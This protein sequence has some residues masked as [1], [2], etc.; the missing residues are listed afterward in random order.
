MIP[1][2][3]EDHT[4]CMVG[5]TARSHR[6]PPQAWQVPHRPPSKYR[7]LP[8]EQDQPPGHSLGCCP[9]RTT[10]RSNGM[11]PSQIEDP[12]TCVVGHTARSHRRPPP[13][14][15]VPHRPPSKYRSVPIVARPATG[16][17][18]GMPSSPNNWAQHWDAALPDRR[19]HHMRGGPHSAKPPQASASLAGPPQTPKQVPVIARGA[20]PA[21]GAQPGMLSSPNNWAQQWDAALPDRRPHHMRGGPHSAKPPQASASLA[22]PPQTPKQIP[23]CAHS[24]KTGHRGT[25]WDAVLPE[26]LGAALGCRPPSTTWAQQCTWAQQWEAALPVQPGRS[27]PPECQAPL[28]GPQPSRP[29]LSTAREPPPGSKASEPNC[30]AASK[31]SSCHQKDNPLTFQ[32]LPPYAQV[33]PDPCA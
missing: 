17:Q 30:N 10:G 25:A 3:I 23:V 28:R 4:T 29:L 15:Q 21:T 11:P 6:R 1:G 8:E 7:S 26:Q 9:P 22:G 20:R 31:R 33:S 24:S 32:E 19:P 2:R 18:P 16:A 13:A 12:T 5:H 14:W 27:N